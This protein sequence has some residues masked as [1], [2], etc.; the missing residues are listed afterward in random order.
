MYCHLVSLWFFHLDYKY[1]PRS[2]T[3]DFHKDVSSQVIKFPLGCVAKHILEMLIETLES[4]WSSCDSLWLYC[5]SCFIFLIKW[6]KNKKENKK[7]TKN[8]NKQKTNKQKTNNNET[9]KTKQAKT[10]PKKINGFNKSWIFVLLL[11]TF[12]SNLG[13]FSVKLSEKRKWKKVKSTD[14]LYLEK[15]GYHI[16]YTQKLG[17]NFVLLWAVWP[18]KHN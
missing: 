12:M 18:V 3:W 13:Y 2:A 16:S 14:R 10:K 5:F 15:V 8:K 6:W 11:D 9:N 17:I 1:A 7:R 4:W